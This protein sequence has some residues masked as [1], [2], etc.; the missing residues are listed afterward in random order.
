NYNSRTAGE[1]IKIE[2]GSDLENG[3]WTAEQEQQM[4][5]L[6]IAMESRPTLMNQRPWHGSTVTRSLQDQTGAQSELGR[7]R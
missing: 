3:G 1:I 7:G 5:S 2:F 4:I 6:L